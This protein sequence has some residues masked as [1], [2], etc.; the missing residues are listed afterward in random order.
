MECLG[1]VMMHPYLDLQQAHAI[2]LTV[3]FVWICAHLAGMFRSSSR[4]NI[5]GFT[6][7]RDS[8][9]LIFQTNLN[10]KIVDFVK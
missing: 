3:F 10:A 5:L 7:A 8:A 2:L 1:E 4:M 9:H 6:I